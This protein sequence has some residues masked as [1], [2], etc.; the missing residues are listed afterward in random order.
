M[1]RGEIAKLTITILA[2]VPWASIT[3]LQPETKD[4]QVYS[5]LL[6]VYAGDPSQRGPPLSQ[7]SRCG[8]CIHGFH[9]GLGEF[10]KIGV[11]SYC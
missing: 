4:T 5:K 7:S 6:G 8:G 3:H 11:L 1:S 2:A 9:F 10:E